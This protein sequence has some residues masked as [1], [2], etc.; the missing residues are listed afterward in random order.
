[1]QFD[2]HGAH[3]MP[4]ELDASSSLDV[5][6]LQMLRGSVFTNDPTQTMPDGTPLP[7]AR[8]MLVPGYACCWRRVR[9][10]RRACPERYE[11]MYRSL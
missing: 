2:Q 1:V 3:Q 8:L 5:V 7:V 9:N 11:T 4:P 10:G 6:A